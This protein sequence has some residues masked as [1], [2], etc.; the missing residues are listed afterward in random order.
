MAAVAADRHLLIGLLALQTGLIDQAA[1]AKHLPRLDQGRRPDPWPTTSSPRAI[2][3]SAPSPL[4]GGLGRG[5][6]ARHGGDVERSLA[7]ITAGRST[8]ESL[9]QLGDADID[10]S[11]ARLDPGSTQ[12]TAGGPRLTLPATPSARP[13]PTGNGTASS[14]HMPT[15]SWA[16]VFVALD[17][18]LHREVALKQILDAHADDPS[19]RQRFVREAEIT[20][21]LEHPGIVPVYG[22]GTYGDGRGRPCYAMRLIRGNSLRRAIELFHADSSLKTDRG[23]RLPRAARCFASSWTCAMPS[24]THTAGGSCTETSSRPT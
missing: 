8:R 5:P 24:I 9:A 1:L 11:I 10:V 15:A 13:P 4:A 18:E 17:T 14:D 12:V 6:V 23:R 21:G 16:L 19:S 2:S 3:T 7:T 20:G 22:L